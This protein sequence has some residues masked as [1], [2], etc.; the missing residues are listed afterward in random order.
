MG[1]DDRQE[2]LER[3]ESLERR[4]RDE[5]D[6]G[7]GCGERHRGH[8]R[9]HHD[10]HC[11][12]RDHRHEHRRG[13]DGGDFEEKRIIDT[14]VTLVSE[15]VVRIL[16]ERQPRG[17]DDGGGERRI[18]D[19]VVGLVSEH[20]QEIISDELDRRFGRPP[21]GGD[22]DRPPQEPGSGESGQS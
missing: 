17:R 3:L 2:I 1:Y 19:L 21:L 20:V 13:R 6:H 7:H 9:G 11:H 15:Q 4:L 14:I 10:D 5:R 22:G 12:D 8:D 18:V 16:D